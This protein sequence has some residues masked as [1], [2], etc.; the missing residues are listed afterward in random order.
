MSK[1]KA[2][3]LKYA[4]PSM[5]T[6]CAVAA[7]FYAILQAASGLFSQAAYGVIAAMV[8]D[9]LDGR[10]ARFTNTCTAFGASFDSIADMLAYGV[11]PAIMIYCWGLF[12]LGRLGY[13][14]CFIFCACVALR[15]ARFNVMQQVVDKKYFQGLSSTIAGGFM[16]TFILACVQYGLYSTYILWFAAGLTLATALIMV[17]NLKFYSFKEI[18]AAP[19]LVA[20]LLLIA[21]IVLISLT[22]RFKG[23]IAW[24]SLASYILINLVLQPWYK[25]GTLIKQNV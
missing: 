6:L 18:H 19:K 23:L 7:S 10:S 13:L 22:Y 17:S 15:L 5:F 1:L 8:F 4:I 21:L 16:V 2:A 9:S 12:R 14:V 25:S 20:L 11:A 3:Q 24:A